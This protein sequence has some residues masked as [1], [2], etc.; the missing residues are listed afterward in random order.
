MDITIHNTHI[1]DTFTILLKKKIFFFI[2]SKRKTK[3]KSTFIQAVAAANTRYVVSAGGTSSPLLVQFSTVGPADGLSK[4][5][6]KGDKSSQPQMNH[7]AKR[8]RGAKL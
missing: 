4:E 8:A 2:L 3:T 5:G 1:L 7:G 6:F